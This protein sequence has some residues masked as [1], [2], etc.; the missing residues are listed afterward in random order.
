MDGDTLNVVLLHL[1]EHGFLDLS[2]DACPFSPAHDWRFFFRFGNFGTRH[3]TIWRLYEHVIYR[4]RLGAN[5][6]LSKLISCLFS[7]FLGKLGL[8]LPKR[9]VLVL[10]GSSCWILY[11]SDFLDKKRN[12]TD[13]DCHIRPLLRTKFGEE[14]NINVV[15]DCWNFKGTCT[16]WVVVIWVVIIVI[17]DDLTIKL[18]VLPGF[19]HQI[20]DAAGVR[21]KFFESLLSFLEQTKILL[22]PT[23]LVLWVVLLIAHLKH[24]SNFSIRPCRSNYLTRHGLSLYR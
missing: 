9:Q 2:S 18:F 12:F 7:F 3:F 16:R 5:L 14:K 22:I 17:W 6:Q 13:Q 21:D 4:G 10:H 11:Q 8:T 19:G 24:N 1:V 20:H 23:T 15:V